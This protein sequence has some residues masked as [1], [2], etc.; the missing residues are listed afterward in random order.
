[1]DGA[2][3]D[4][5]RNIDSRHDGERFVS[6]AEF[7][8]IKRHLGNASSRLFAVLAGTET[9]DD[10]AAVMS[11][12]HDHPEYL[13]ARSGVLSGGSTHRPPGTQEVSARAAGPACGDRP[14]EQ[15]RRYL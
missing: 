8:E 5:P 6:F 15:Q 14:V 11:W 2:T 7:A 4:Y 12:F 10:V 13:A 9:P 3:T 1:M